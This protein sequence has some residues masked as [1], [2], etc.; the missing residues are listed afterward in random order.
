[1]ATASGSPGYERLGE[2]RLSLIDAVA[3]SAGFM[4]PVF[5]AAL[6]IPLMAGFS[7]TGEGAGV[8]TPLAVIV[9]AVGVGAIGWIVATYARR[10]HAAG[11]LYDYVTHGLGTAWPAGSTARPAGV[12]VRTPKPAPRA[13]GLG[14]R[15]RSVAPQTRDRS[16][17]HA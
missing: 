5:S 14:S 9:A 11:S 16:V 10:I 12:A 7:A 17:G 3:Q 1:M 15:T 2:T 8:A 13:R 6:L 4:A